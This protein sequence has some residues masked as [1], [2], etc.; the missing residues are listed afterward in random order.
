MRWNPPPDEDKTETV[1]DTVTHARREYPQIRLQFPNGATEDFQFPGDML[2][3]FR[4]QVPALL[5]GD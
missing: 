4:G 5:R 2:G 3:C 1:H